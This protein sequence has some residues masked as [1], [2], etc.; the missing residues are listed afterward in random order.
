MWSYFPVIP[1][2]FVGNDRPSWDTTR[3]VW[4]IFPVTGGHHH[5]IRSLEFSLGGCV[6]IFQF[7]FQPIKTP[8]LPCIHI[9]TKWW[10]V[11]QP[12]QVHWCKWQDLWPL[13]LSEFSSN[14]TYNAIMLVSE[15]SLD[16][17]SQLF[18]LWCIPY[19]SILCRLGL[20]TCWSRRMH[21]RR[22]WQHFHPL[23]EASLQCEPRQHGGYLLFWPCS[24]RK[25]RHFHLV[26]T[27]DRSFAASGLQ[28]WCDLLKY[29]LL[30]LLSTGTKRQVSCLKVQRRGCHTDLRMSLHFENFCAFDH[31]GTGVIDAIE[32]RL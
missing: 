19:R 30:A 32:H 23:V 25:S 5:S 26:Q 14:D 29:L 12:L 7:K 8:P 22:I 24:T 18:M 4:D 2:A 6:F 21:Y 10:F 17:F 15:Y 27:L 9:F 1:E 3:G 16:T 20:R 13:H 28:Q 11:L 31:S